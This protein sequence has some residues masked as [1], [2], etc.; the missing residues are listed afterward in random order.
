MHNAR[1]RVEILFVFA[2]LLY[3]SGKM[4]DSIYNP[5]SSSYVLHKKINVILK[6]STNLES[7]VFLRKTKKNDVTFLRYF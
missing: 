3:Y 4:L 7:Y 1:E 6:L 5:R 2:D